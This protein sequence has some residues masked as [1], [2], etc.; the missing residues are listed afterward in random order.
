MEDFYT[1]KKEEERSG[2]GF[3]IMRSFMDELT[4]KSECG[5]G[6]T[7]TLKKHFSKNVNR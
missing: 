6:T 5:A 2:L 4:V 1:S 7:V 3:T